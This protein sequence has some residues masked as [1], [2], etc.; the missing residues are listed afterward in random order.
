MTEAGSSPVEALRSDLERAQG[1]LAVVRADAERRAAELQERPT[2]E[3]QLARNEASDRAELIDLQIQ[4][5]KRDLE[6]AQAI[7]RADAIGARLT[8]HTT[9]VMGPAAESH[10]RL[11]AH[12]RGA[13]A[14]IAE[15]TG[16][17][18]AT[19]QTTKQLWA[20]GFEGFPPQLGLEVDAEL[21]QQMQRLAKAYE[22]ALKA[23]GLA[24][25]Q[26][27]QLLRGRGRR[28]D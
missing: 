5:L 7:E 25:R 6:Q 21:V 26:V 18:N 2:R 14:E 1:E 22:N 27:G 9:A 16:Y 19:R 3:L 8:R 13:A 4:R 15:L 11:W 17:R 23:V 10:R 12:V 24:D 28:I 20:N